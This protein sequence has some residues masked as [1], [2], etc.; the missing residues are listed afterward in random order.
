[1]L[2]QEFDYKWD[3]CHVMVKKSIILDHIISS[4]G[5]EVDKAKVD[6]IA[7]LP[8]PTCVKDIRPFLG[9]I[10]FYQRFFKDFS[11]IAKPYPP[12]S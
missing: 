5:I 7:S 3:K 12:P 10:D 1:M 2:G 9:H 8:H 6:L 4:E 11:K